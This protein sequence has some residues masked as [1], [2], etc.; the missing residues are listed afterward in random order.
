MKNKNGLRSSLLLAMGSLLLFIS[1]CKNNNTVTDIEGNVYKTIVVGDQVWMAENLYVSTF[2]NGD[3][4]PEAKSEAEWKKYGEASQPA[5]CYYGNDKA[6]GKIYGKLYNWYAV[7]DPR[8]IAPAGWHLPVEAE[9]ETLIDN[10][11]GGKKA[12]ENMKSIT[13]WENSG[14]GTNKSGFQ[15]FPGGHCLFDGRFEDIGKGCYWWSATTTDF[16]SA[17]ACIIGSINNMVNIFPEEVPRGLSVRCLR[18][19]SPVNSIDSLNKPSGETEQ[20]DTASAENKADENPLTQYKQSLPPSEGYIAVLNNDGK[21][22]FVYEDGKVLIEC[23]YEGVSSFKNG[24]AVV[25]KSSDEDWQTK[26]HYIDANGNDL[27]L[28]FSQIDG[29]SCAEATVAISDV[30]VQTDF[31]KNCPDG[32]M[33][34]YYQG[35]EGSG[36]ETFYPNINIEQ[37]IA[38]LANTDT[39]FGPIYKKFDGSSLEFKDGDFNIYI[40]VNKNADG[41]V[42]SVNFSKNYHSMGSHKTFTPKG[43]GVMVSEGTGA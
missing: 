11:G 27:G 43:T 17:F 12:G 21:W 32:V 15:G 1:A 24:K 42:T 36:G 22:G 20:R 40:T 41:I 31:L 7:N 2:R 9:W 29:T 28:F 39:E 26:Y 19:N 4:I 38:K 14:N 16:N 10:F 5:W 6:K 25:K 33:S 18:D 23:Q 37:L 34:V 3:P 8:G 30:L 13:G 35:D